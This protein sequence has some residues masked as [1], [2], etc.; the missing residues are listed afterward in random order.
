[1]D[2]KALEAKVNKEPLPKLVQTL[3]DSFE[4]LA[5]EPRYQPDLLRTIYWLIGDLEIS[6]LEA[7]MTKVYDTAEGNPRMM[8]EIC[9]R[10]RKEPVLD[11]DLVN[12]V[13]D[14]Y[15][16]RQ[17]KELDMSIVLLLVLGGFV[18]MRYAWREAD[19]TSLQFI[20]GCLLII[21]L[22]TR[23]FF[24]SAKRNIL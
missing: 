24:N 17:T 13:A 18:A 1:L 20:G 15:L 8:R 19:N 6:D 7:V 4:G 12:E 14:S 22:F 16:G 11:L 5:L 2:L 9:E 23:A 10:L 21:L 3:I